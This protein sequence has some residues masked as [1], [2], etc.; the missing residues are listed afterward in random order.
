MATLSLENR[1]L[2]IFLILVFVFFLR[3]YN[4]GYHDFWYDEV[5]TIS[6]AQHPWS[7]WNAPLYWILLH[8]WIKIFR[9]SEFSLRF[10]SL[11]FNFLSVILTF[12]LGKELFNKKVGIIAS[13][14]IGLS[15]FHL[16]YA[17]EARDYSMVLFL[18]TLSSYLFFK[19]I[20]EER[21]KLWLFFILVSLCGLYTS[22]FYIFLFLAQG[23][24]LIFLRKFKVDLKV[25]ICFLFITLGFSFYLPPFLSKFYFIWQ[26]FWIPKPTWES[27]IITIENFIL[28]YNGFS[29]IYFVSDVLVV[30]FFIS[31]LWAIRKKELK[32]SFIFCIFLA[33]IPI[34]LAF[35][36]SKLF[37][38]LYL[39]R[40][41]IIFSPYF[42]LILSLGI[43]FLKRMLR[44]AS[45]IILVTML[46]IADY[47]YCKDWMFMPFEH[48]T[49]TCV[50]RP[51][52]PIVKFLND[53]IEPQDIIAFTNTHAYSPFSYYVSKKSY[54]IYLF[55]DPQILNPNWKRSIAEGRYCV[56]FYK[57]NNLEFK[58]LWVIYSDWERSG[59][60]DE[61][62]LSVKNWLGKNLK[63]EF[64]KEF[65]GL[66]IYRYVR[67]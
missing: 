49:G 45:L 67:M 40:G 65:D 43:V 5:I 66:W 1:K 63:V 12:L 47:G 55:F 24:Y 7:N 27:L 22:Y 46:L 58:R 6:Y 37:F 31:A 21:V 61:S 2:G 56:P 62:S 17:Q 38:S 36:F 34:I 9:V 13:I 39:D 20:K 48:H 3:L 26:G 11:I 50:K 60:L 64:V 30:L 25:I 14:F 41:L 15:P 35:I 18:G 19:A 44:A 23:S 28:G 33:F 42:Y 16:W 8:Y 29:F 51:I 53:Q 59:N 54:P 4:L 52:K 57:I 32:A 10:P